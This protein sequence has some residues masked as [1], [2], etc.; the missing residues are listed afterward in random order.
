MDFVCCGGLRIDFLITPDGQA[1]V[2]EI[3]GN[4]LYAAV[5]A[6]VWSVRVGLLARVGENYPAGWLDA[7]EQHGLDVSGVH[8]VPGT[9]DMRTFYAYTDSHTRTDTDPATHF[10]RIGVPLPDDL[11][12][13]V[14]ST[15][16]QDDPDEYEPLAVRPDDWPQALD[17]A[18]ALHLSPIS[19]CTHT[20]LPTRARQS[21][22]AQVT[23]DPGER[24]MVPRLRSHVE[25]LLQNLDVFLPSEMEVRSLLG[26]VDL[27][28]AAAEFAHHGPRI[29]VIKMGDQGA[30]VYE[31]DLKRR[32]HVPPYPAR[33]VDVTGAGDSFCG[34][35]MVGLATTGDPIRAALYGTVS[36]SFAI[37]G[38]GALYAMSANPVEA[39]QRLIYLEQVMANS[40][41]QI[42]NIKRAYDDEEPSPGG[43]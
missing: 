41:H 27:W 39:R 3:G 37:E 11:I 26:A 42:S 4:A 24:Y 21:S 36:A 10:A 28:D 18:C 12:D 1:H 6:R 32:T 8:V 38:Y 23:A 35:F 17:G 25:K 20:S 31:R 34:G 13:Y 33:V 7:L 16:G 19:V 43:I 14:H 22:V 40:K 9:Q 15:P 2:R 30:L 29:V 5:G